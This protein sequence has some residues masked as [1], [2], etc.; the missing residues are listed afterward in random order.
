METLTQP[1][2]L[3]LLGQTDQG[4]DIPP[5]TPDNMFEFGIMSCDMTCKIYT[6]AATCLFIS[7]LLI[8]GGPLSGWAHGNLLLLSSTLMTTMQFINSISLAQGPN[9]YWN[10]DIS[11]RRTLFILALVHFVTWISSFISEA[12]KTRADNTGINTN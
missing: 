9:W 10:I 5:P 11:Y 1:I 12:V 8:M 2:A 7:H 6:L 4:D 3:F